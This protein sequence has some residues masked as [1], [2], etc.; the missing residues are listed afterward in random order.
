MSR[1]DGELTAASAASVELE[2]LLAAFGSVAAARCDRNDAMARF[3]SGA[4]GWRDA[5]QT[6][7]KAECLE[8]IKQ[9][10]TDMSPLSL[11]QKMDQQTRPN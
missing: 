2:E 4:E 3:L 7:T 1:Y 8:H 11:R 9:V 6:G 5:G 10:W